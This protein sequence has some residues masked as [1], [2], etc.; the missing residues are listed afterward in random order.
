LNFEIKTYEDYNYIE[1]HEIESDKTF[2]NA[3]YFIFDVKS[4]E[5]INTMEYTGGFCA[6]MTTRYIKDHNL[7]ANYIMLAAIPQYYNS[8]RYMIAYLDENYNMLNYMFG[9]NPS[10]YMYFKRKFKK[11]IIRDGIV[12]ELEDDARFNALTELCCKH[13]I[14][15]FDMMINDE[16]IKLHD[17]IKFDD[18]SIFKKEAQEKLEKL[19]A[20]Y[21][22]LELVHNSLMF[23]DFTGI[24]IDNN[25][26]AIKSYQFYSGIKDEDAYVEHMRAKLNGREFSKDDIDRSQY[27]L[28]IPFETIKNKIEHVN[29]I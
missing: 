3:E 15:D 29:I 26:N 10:D 21:L 14:L 25:C 8:Y 6:N 19:G 9:S 22:E 11:C 20:S 13:G 4:D 23:L 2:S 5:F 16:P 1:Y 12:F 24:V 17:K 27:I 7:D 18:F 28:H